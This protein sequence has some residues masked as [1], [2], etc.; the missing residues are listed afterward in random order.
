MVDTAG[1]RISLLSIVGPQGLHD[2]TSDN[3]RRT[4]LQSYPILKTY[5]Y[6]YLIRGWDFRL[7]FLYKM[8]APL[9]HVDLEQ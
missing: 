2:S 1:H 3:T 9:L 5:T 7:S 8:V 4:A 6:P